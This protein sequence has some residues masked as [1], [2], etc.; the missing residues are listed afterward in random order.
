[1]H[2]DE[3]Y[4]IAEHAL[5]HRGHYMSV[6]LLRLEPDYGVVQGPAAGAADGT[7]GDGASRAR[8]VRPV[9]GGDLAGMAVRYASLMRY[10]GRFRMRT[11]VRKVFAW[12]QIHPHT[13]VS[14]CI[15]VGIG[16]AI[17]IPLGW[18]L[19]DSVAALLGA[20]IGAGAAVGAALWAAN[21]KQLQEDAKADLRTR[22]LAS[23]IAMAITGE[24]ATAVRTIDLLA[25]ELRMA[26]DEADRIGNGMPVAGVLEGCVVEAPMCARFIDRIDAFGDDS[27]EVF[28]AI[29]T[30][31]GT[32]AYLK[33]LSA[34]VR[35][36]VWPGTRNVVSIRAETAAL[37]PD[38]LLKTLAVLAKYNPSAGSMRGQVETLLVQDREKFARKKRA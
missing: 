14:L 9:E 24:V 7:V 36:D 28:K 35:D 38:A 19:P 20:V 6:L 25:R 18:K 17:T 2:D 5:E 22:H 26:I 8:H 12:F 23:L 16:V 34:I 33:S 32:N 11:S 37:H 29:D 30:I 31:L 13:L 15:G 10:R 27:P 4:I 21:A 3:A 1:M